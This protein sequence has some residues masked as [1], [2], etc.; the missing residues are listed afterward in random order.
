MK[1]IPA[2]PD[3]SPLIALSKMESLD[4]LIKLYK[5]VIVTPSVWKEAVAEGK[6]MGAR[7]AAYLEKVARK[8][9]FSAARLTLQ[10][11]GLVQFLRDEAGIGMGEAE[12]LA[13]AKSRKALA[14]LD[15]KGARAVAVGLGVAHTGTAGLLFEAFLRSL[16]DYEELVALLERLGKM[17]WVSP[18]LLA[19]ILRRA[20]EVEKK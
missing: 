19:G 5:K 6:A 3:A 17:A 7:D 12:V 8:N 16:L 18:E 13:I 2:V 10:E 9:R 15:E 11:K 14:V 1:P 20:K 4:L